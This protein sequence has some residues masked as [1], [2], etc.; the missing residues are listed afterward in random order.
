M[1]DKLPTSVKIME[2]GPRDGLQNEKTIVDTA[3]KIKFIEKLVDAG[4]KRIEVTA[5]V[6]PRWIVPLADQL[7]VAVGV[8]KKPGVSYAALVPNVQGYE[9]A[10]SSQ[11]I[12]E[13]SVVVAASNT[14][15][16]KNL[17]ADTQRVMER[18]RELSARAHQDKCPFRAYI[19][20]V[21]GCPYEGEVAVEQI[22]LLTKE[23]LD[24]GAYEISLGDTI[25]AASP[26][27]TMR[28]LNA[29]L[30]HV[31]ASRLAL[32]MH[33][34]RGTALANIFA[35]LL[36][37]ISS[38]DSSAGGLGGCPYAPGAS[39]NMSTEDLVSMLDNMN[40]HTGISVEKICEASLQI[41]KVLKK[42]LPSK[43]LAI[44]R[45]AS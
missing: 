2:V 4:I 41:E 3:T 42:K 31:P 19:S 17:N 22:I 45:Q 26:L 29:L 20:C 1:H 18:Y 15:N 44:F 11:K 9:R 38:F 24:I 21:F 10:M 35:G 33:D 12:D 43:I 13:V 34:T 7:E 27:S 37:G 23:L 6:S 14:H 5:F 16:I 32:H 8:K 40:I 28:I 36:L 39:G 30:A 25:G